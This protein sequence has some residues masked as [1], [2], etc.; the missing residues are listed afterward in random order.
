MQA[1]HVVNS[2]TPFKGSWEIAV[3]NHEEACK[4][5]QA[6][7]HGVVARVICLFMFVG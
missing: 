7:E 5:L 2:Y 1:V 3:L 4:P 6:K